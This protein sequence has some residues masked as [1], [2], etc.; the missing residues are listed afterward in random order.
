[1]TGGVHGKAAH[2]ANNHED[3]AN[4]IGALAKLIDAAQ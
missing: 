3:G 1:M 4:A 2:A